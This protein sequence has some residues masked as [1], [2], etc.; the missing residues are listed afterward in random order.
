MNEFGGVP[1]VDSS[2]SIRPRPQNFSVDRVQKL[3]YT[4]T[5]DYIGMFINRDEMYACFVH[6]K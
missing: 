1:R 6:N 5:G 2:L 3:S 4:K